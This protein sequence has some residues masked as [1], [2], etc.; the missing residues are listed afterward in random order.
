MKKNKFLGLA[1]LVIGFAANT[2]AAE[3]PTNTAQMQA[4]DRKSVV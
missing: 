1:T 2:I 4:I 3:L